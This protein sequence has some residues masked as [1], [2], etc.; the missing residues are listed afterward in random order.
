[1]N[2]QV[3]NRQKQSDFLMQDIYLRIRKAV[4]YSIKIVAS[5]EIT[6]QTIDK[7]FSIDI[8]FNKIKQE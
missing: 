8:P 7:Y 2:D 6:K 1:M 3:S 5:K 4:E